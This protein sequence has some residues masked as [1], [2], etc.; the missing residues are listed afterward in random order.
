MI[1]LSVVLTVGIYISRFQPAVCRLTDADRSRLAAVVQAARQR[2]DIPGVAVSIVN[3]SSVL[4]EAGF[5]VANVSNGRPMTA[6]TRLPLGSTTKAFTSALLA[7][8]MDKHA[9]DD[10]KSVH[11][12]YI[13]ALGL[14]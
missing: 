8:L 2:G 1:L 12:D 9:T 6:D 7:L 4:V 3:G 5:G 10:V 11:V 13:I 14:I